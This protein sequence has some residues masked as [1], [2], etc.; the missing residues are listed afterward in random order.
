[1]KKTILAAAMITVGL[2]AGCGSGGGTTPATGTTSLSG[3]VADGYLVGATVFLD[4]NGNYQLDA[5]EPSATTDANGAYTLTVDPADVGKYPIVALAIKG[6][7]M[8]KDTGLPVAN[9]Y[10]LSMPA[11]ATSGTVN[12]NF[13]SPMSSQLREMMETGKYAS[14]QQAMTALAAKLGMTVGTN[15][16]EDYMLANN[17]T[18]HTA[19][20]NM[21]SLMGG[22]MAQVMGTSGTTVTVDVNR[23]RGM[24]GMIFSNMS[25]IK[26]PNSQTAMT[27]LM[28]TMTT[29]LGN[30]PMMSA[31]QPYLNMSTAFRGG[32][33][34]GMS[35]TG[36]MMN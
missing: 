26:G 27:T 28:G 2:I 17:A 36:G 6:Q 12:S 15:M 29:T 7:T 1:M 34:G 33:V 19:A 22:E 24:M 16:L 31:G 30:M 10:V 4:K 32:M 20:Q 14:M 23:Y 25:S 13:I 5:G 11:T 18:M 9:S 3:K 35:G 8:D 21:A